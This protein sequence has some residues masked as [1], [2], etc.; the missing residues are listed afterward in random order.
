METALRISKMI[1]C[2]LKPRQPKISQIER[3]QIKPALPQK[4]GG[5]R[6]RDLGPRPVRRWIK[7]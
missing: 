2:Q 4:R 7:R 5:R 1:I 6:E 3:Y